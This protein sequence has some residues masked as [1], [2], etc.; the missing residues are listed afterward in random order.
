MNNLL[1]LFV[2]F[3]LLNNIFCHEFGKQNEIHDKEHLKEHL[4]DKIDVDRTNWTPAQERFYYFK[5][6]DTNKD[7]LLDGLEIS[8]A[9]THHDHTKAKKPYED[10]QIENLVDAVMDDMDGNKD[11][12][13]SF[14]EYVD[15]TTPGRLSQDLSI[16]QVV[17]NTDHIVAHIQQIINTDKKD[18]SQEQH[19]F[20]YFSIH[21]TNK[22][23]LIDGLE[24][25]KHYIH[26]NEDKGITEIP[27]DEELEDIVSFVMDEMDADNNGFITYSEYMAK[28]SE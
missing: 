25:L 7:D 27:K 16:K 21:D 22:D 4:Q 10:Y 24:I 15:R 19:Y 12:Y 11:G 23:S 13:I 20:Y 28:V 18:W 14:P 9:Y 17:T 2:C 3:F 5:L 6:H 8:K 1:S 26:D